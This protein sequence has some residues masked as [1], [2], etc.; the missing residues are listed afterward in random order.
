MQRICAVGKDNQG[1]ASA[2]EIDL[3]IIPHCGSWRQEGLKSEPSLGSLKIHEDS[4]SGCAQ[5][6]QNG[7]QALPNLKALITT[8]LFPMRAQKTN[9]DLL[10]CWFPCPSFASSPM[11]PWTFSTEPFPTVSLG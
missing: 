1:G 6:D 9:Q 8:N 4:C 2:G 11:G 7:E 10:L 5:A 3:S